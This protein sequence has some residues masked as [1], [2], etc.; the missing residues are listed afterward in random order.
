MVELTVDLK[1][2]HP[3]FLDNRQHMRPI[4]DRIWAYL[5]QEFMQLHLRASQL[6]WMLQDVTSLSHEVETAV[7][8]YLVAD[9]AKARVDAFQK[10]GVFWRLSGT[11]N[12][13]I[14]VTDCYAYGFL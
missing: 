13:V 12:F 9:S 14:C 3:S 1:V 8:S 10:F 6:I 11:T 2:V 7:A 4:V 5:A